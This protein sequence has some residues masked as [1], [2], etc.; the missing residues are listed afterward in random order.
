MGATRLRDGI[1]RIMSEYDWTSRSTHPNPNPNPNPNPIP[2]PKPNPHPNDWTC[3]SE[4]FN[5]SHRWMQL[6]DSVELGL[7]Q[8]VGEQYAVR[9]SMGCG[10]WASVP[11]LAVSHPSE[12]TQHGLYLQYLF[13]SDMSG[14]YLC[15]GQGTS[16]LKAAFGAQAASEHLAMV[17][18]FVRARFTALLGGDSGFDLSGQID[19]RARGKALAASYEQGAIVS[20][21][22]ERGGCPPE[23]ILLE[24][25]DLA[26]EAYAA[27]LADPQYLEQI[28]GPM[29][30]RL[31]TAAGVAGG[32]KKRVS[33]GKLKAGRSSGQVRV[34]ALALT[35]TRTL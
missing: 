2:T 25:L 21:L 30:A 8:S 24:Q 34:L 31:A 10:G 20:L 4:A 27:V 28:K 23:E 18:D 29:D 16:K 32:S 12:S 26:K 3:R 19:L 35:L 22:Y 17:G 9:S 6:L 14:V 7:Q 15:L 5:K 13:R 33:L 1:E 11:W